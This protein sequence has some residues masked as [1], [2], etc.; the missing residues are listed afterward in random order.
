MLK[1]SMKLIL[2]KSFSFIVFNMCHRVKLN[3][4]ICQYVN[5]PGLEKIQIF[6]KNGI[7][8][9]FF[10]KKGFWTENIHIW[11][12]RSVTTVILY[13]KKLGLKV[14][15]MSKEEKMGGFDFHKIISLVF[16]Q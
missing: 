3:Y 12:S 13:T 11:G 10:Y 6:L 15:I 14:K 16:F 5:F 9:N 4:G 1:A 8:A 7:Q 2:Y